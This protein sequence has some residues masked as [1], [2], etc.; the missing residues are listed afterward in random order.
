MSPHPDFQ[1]LKHYSLLIADDEVKE[2]FQL[3]SALHDYFDRTYVAKNGTEAW[4][5]YNQYQPDFVMLDIRMPDETGLE[6][7]KKIRK[8]NTTRPII[9]IT[10]YENKEVF[11]ESI[12]LHVDDFLLKPL[13]RSDII[14]ALNRVLQNLPTMSEIDEHT[15]YN[16]DTKQVMQGDETVQLSHK[17]FILLE[18]LMEKREKV[19]AYEEIMSKLYPE[20][21]SELELLRTVMKKLR[22]KLPSDAVLTVTGIGYKFKSLA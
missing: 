22:K 4:E 17:E 8:L 1:R 19:V 5:L 21:M 14:G 15:H 12:R 20:R 7:A 11:I 6:V 10:A 3:E 2:L 9:F 16:Y 13:R 18:L